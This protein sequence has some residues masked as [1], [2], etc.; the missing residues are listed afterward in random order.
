MNSALPNF[1]GLPRIP[2]LIIPT[3]IAFLWFSPSQAA[4]RQAISYVHD[5]QPLL[6]SRCAACHACYQA[7]CQL[8]LNSW[9]GV[10]RGLSQKRKVYNPTR[11]HS[12]EPTRLFQDALTTEGW[13]RQDFFPIIAE[14]P[15]LGYEESYITTLIEQRRTHPGMANIKKPEESREC[16]TSF[17]ELKQH[18]RDNPNYGMPY[19]LPALDNAQIDVFAKWTQQGAK[20]PSASEEA[21]NW[22][23]A[24]HATAAKRAE[25]IEQIQSWEQFLNQSDAKH[26]LVSRYLYEHLFMAHINFDPQQR[27]FYRLVRSKN[28]C[29]IQNSRF[30]QEVSTK[31]PFGNPIHRSTADVQKQEP[32][33]AIEASY[34]AFQYCFKKVTEEITTKSHMLYKLN[35]QKLAD[36]QDLFFAGEDWEVEHLPG[37]VDEIAGTASDNANPFIVFQDIP[38]KARYRFLLSEAEYTVRTFIRG[39][40]CRGGT[41]VNSIDERFFVLFIDPDSDLFANNKTYAKTTYDALRTAAHYGSDIEGYISSLGVTQLPKFWTRLKKEQS[42]YRAARDEEYQYRDQGFGIKDLWRGDGE[43]AN[44]NSILT[45]MRHYDSASVNQGA[46]GPMPKTSLVLDYPLLERFV[47]NL[48]AGFDVFGDLGHQVLSR[49][50]MSYLRTEG[51][52]NFLDFMPAQDDFRRKL[53]NSWYQGAGTT[54]ESAVQALC[55][56]KGLL[57]KLFGTR[58]QSTIDQCHPLYSLDREPNMQFDMQTTES[59]THGFGYEQKRQFFK[60]VFEHLGATQDNGLLDSALAKQLYTNTLPDKDTVKQ[61]LQRIA[62][63]VAGEEYSA[64]QFVRFF[65]NLSYLLVKVPGK[66]DRV[67]SIIR[68]KFH[69][70]ILIMSAE[71]QRRDLSK[72]T[73]VLAPGFIGMYPNM[74]FTVHEKHLDDFI[75]RILRM[76]TQADYQWMLK[77]YG[78]AQ[79]NPKFWT[80][81][82]EILHVANPDN[83]AQTG[84]LEG[85]IIDLNRYGIEYNDGDAPDD[86]AAQM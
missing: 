66:A 79:D 64:G 6:N 83:P 43:Q 70:N 40:V 36:Y 22:T 54:A 5:I 55:M 27:E 67:Y 25:L 38:A 15:Y 49:V 12:E 58:Q 63:Q 41:A 51:E 19:G 78:V 46:I 47:Y 81:Y 39:P 65:P 52:S 71:A 62:N 75:K 21:R 20:G 77:S 26:R 53:R 28:G 76:K 9:D 23:P 59:D 68:D 3:L 84:F 18:L 74:F 73:L 86:V 82:D 34:H 42:A 30:I 16:K 45:V 60:A 11:T 1:Y 50:Y 13:R 80:V 8:K 2:Q 48:A 85:G 61:R 57:S 4:N 10:A 37:F 14:L 17:T 29:N 35:P 31:R 24:P 33:A 32:E 56:H 7:P 69:K 72:D 44:P